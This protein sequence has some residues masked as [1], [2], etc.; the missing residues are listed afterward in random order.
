M[1][2][3]LRPW[4]VPLPL[5][6][7]AAC[8]D[9]DDSPAAPVPEPPTAAELDSDVAQAW[10]DLVYEAVRTEALSPPVAA[11]T[12]GYAA[13]AFYESVVDG[14]PGGVSLGGQLNELDPLP[15]APSGEV[16]WG[17]AANAAL[18]QFLSG[19]PLIDDAGVLSDV[20][21]LAAAQLATLGAD[22]DTEVIDRSVTWG[23]T[24]AD[25]I[26]DWAAGDGFDVHNNCVYAV[27]AAGGG[28]WEPTPPAFAANPLQPCWGQ[29]RTFA[30]VDGTD[31]QP[32]GPPAFSTDP[33]SAFYSEAL[34]VYVTVEAM[35]A[36]PGDATNVERL[37]IANFWADGPGATGTPAGHWVRI[38]SQVSAQQ[39]LPLSTAA[40]GFAKIGIAM[41]DA[42]ISCWE[43]K[44]SFN[45]LRP[46]TYIDAVIENGWAT[47]FGATIVPLGT[48][49]FPEYTSGHSTQSGAASWVLHDLLG[50]FEFTDDTHAGV[51]DARTFASFL[52]AAEEAAI[53]RLYGG[54]HYRSAIEEGVE[55]G[56]CVG[57]TLL[58][59]VQFLE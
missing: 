14:I 41:A 18:E 12:Y 33:L 10:M 39:S 20:A 26:L 48:P 31:C 3:D 54:I 56:R 43:A 17:V 27:P 24:V 42:F 38:L 47:D 22:L 25:A 46:V 44:Y 8:S 5:V 58:S 57:Q 49:A 7:L 50:S 36:E 55:Q 32:D 59:N 30:L 6:L 15:A 9:D 52:E 34:E 51:H 45:L 21:D 4:L 53:S 40:E 1:P 28:A 16:H 11:R 29:M 35:D 19:Y 2:L 13:V 37:A 23:Q